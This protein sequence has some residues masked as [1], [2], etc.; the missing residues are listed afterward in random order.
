MM[1]VERQL[2]ENYT[3]HKWPQA[4]Q[5]FERDGDGYRETMLN[6]AWL[7]WMARADLLSN[8]VASGD[9]KL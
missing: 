6:T 7:G 9:I 1:E 3:R 8:A 5:T 2:F 4:D